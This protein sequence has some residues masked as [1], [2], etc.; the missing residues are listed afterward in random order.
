[1]ILDERFP[2]IYEGNVIYY[3]KSSINYDNL[4]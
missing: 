1:M 2:N 3:S 4:I